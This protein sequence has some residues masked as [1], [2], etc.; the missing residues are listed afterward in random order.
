MPTQRFEGVLQYLRT[1]FQN[2]A[3]RD[4]TDAELLRRFL[5]HR[6]ET[7]F[8]L[9]VQRH[10]AMVLS[11][12][13][14]VLGDAHGAEDSLQATFIVLSR[15]AA[16]IR[17]T[18]SLANWLY[19]VAQ[20]IALKAKTQMTARRR[21]ERPLTDT[22]SAEA[23]DN[24]SLKELRTILDEEIARLADKY[25]API[26]LCY[27]E[28]KSYDQ[29]ARE[30]GW[31]KS[32]L[33][34]RL[35]RA[36]E[37]LRRQL[38]RRGLALSAGV[39]A[40]GL[41]AK[42]AGAHVPAMLTIKTVKAALSVAAGNA[43]SSV[44]ISAHAL[45]L[46]QET[47]AAAIA[48]KAKAV[49]MVLAFAMAVGGAGWAGYHGL[50]DK[51]LPAQVANPQRPAVKEQAGG[52]AKKDPPAATAPKVAT[53]ADLQNDSLPAG[54]VSRLG[55]NQGHGRDVA[56]SPDGRIIAAADYNHQIYL[57]DA[58]TIK[59]VGQ[60]TAGDPG[61]AGT[62]SR[63]LHCIAFSPDGKRLVCG[64]G[65]PDGRP[66]KTIR[67]WEV[68]T[69]NL[70]HEIVGHESAVLAVAFSPAA[71][72]FASASADQ[73]VCLWDGAT[74]RE[75]RR[76]RGHTGMVQSV[77]FSPDGKALA[78]S[79]DDQTIRLWDVASGLELLQL[80]GHLDAVMSVCF[81]PDGKSLASASRDQTVRLW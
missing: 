40:T 38:V 35:T 80:V 10:G 62:N 70:I 19:G 30:L 9:L 20:R 1:V 18:G 72:V 50:T 22:P 79:G 73:T 58:A 2:P 4:L 53:D 48:T 46:A 61:N 71:D 74:G 36:R 68:A 49:V 31:S 41:C 81:S 3:D 42:V 51:S 55:S 13:R 63:W 77:A 45:A 67:V 76:L 25:R 33:A 12:C 57:W 21:R 78:T 24:A 39:L 23:L 27:F 11:V 56:F 37:L 14:R 5:T 8:A 29:A 66:L 15:R 44:G 69:G 47:T 7:A 65:H 6:E 34:K 32:S 64:E 26:V 17:C 52:A 28:D 43:L 54:A 75:L 16:S 60:L 59:K